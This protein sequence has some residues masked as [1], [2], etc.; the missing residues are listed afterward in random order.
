MPTKRASNRRQNLHQTVSR[1]TIMNKKDLIE[2]IQFIVEATV[3]LFVTV[4]IWSFLALICWGLL[5]VVGFHFS[6]IQV[7][8]FVLLVGFVKNFLFKL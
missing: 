6:Y 2:L 1:S 3:T 8:A 4:V 7:T 5:T